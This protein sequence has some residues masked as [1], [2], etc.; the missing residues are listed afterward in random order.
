M[1]EFIGI[2]YV[3]GFGCVFKSLYSRYK[4]DLFSCLIMAATWP[5]SMTIWVIIM[6][7]AIIETVTKF[8]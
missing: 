4:G 5:I 3:I 2:S 6:C 7:C 8:Y 1:I